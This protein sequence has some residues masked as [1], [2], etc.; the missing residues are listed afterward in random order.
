MIHSMFLGCRQV[1]WG[2]LAGTSLLPFSS[3]STL[4]VKISGWLECISNLG[5]SWSFIAGRCFRNTNLFV[6]C[7][8]SVFLLTTIPVIQKAGLLIQN[9]RGHRAQSMKDRSLISVPQYS[10]HDGNTKDGIHRKVFV[11]IIICKRVWFPSETRKHLL[12]VWLKGKKRADDEI[13]KA[14]SKFARGT[15][16]FP[17][18]LVFLSF[19]MIVVRHSSDNK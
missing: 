7:L 12:W 13:R 8:F 6:L 9:K 2:L 19:I 11:I 3:L 14:T 17:P 4:L 15:A 16:S 5:N 1:V 10:P 18:K